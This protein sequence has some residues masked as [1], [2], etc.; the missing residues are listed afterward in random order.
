MDKRIFLAIKINP[1]PELLDVFDLLRD[2]L[3]GGQIKWADEEQLHVT[4]K[5][6]GE[7][8]DNKITEIVDVVKDCCAQ[9][10]SFSFDICSPGY[11]RKRQEPSV[12]FL[13]SAKT[14]ALVVLQADLDNRFTGLGVP[15]EE[16][17]FKPHL[18]LGRVKSVHDTA[19]FYDLM[20][21]FPHRPVQ[22]IPASDLTLFESRLKPSGPE[23]IALERFSLKLQRPDE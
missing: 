1:E 2:E 18:T 22:T 7:T 13:Q 19:L 21:Q 20:K 4:L 23:Y 12:V 14:E 5:F 16:R 17:A 9:H 15:K 6:F 3:S 11:F 8:P 10:S